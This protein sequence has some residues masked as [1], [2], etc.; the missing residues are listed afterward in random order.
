MLNAATRWGYAGMCSALTVFA[1]MLGA[2]GHACTPAF[3]VGQ[4]IY[5]IRLYVLFDAPYILLGIAVLTVL[6]FA[7]MTIPR[8]RSLPSQTLNWLAAIVPAC[9]LVIALLVPL[10]GRCVYL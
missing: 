2:F 3:S 7:I 6:V 9:V 4:A 8:I 10:H 1:A 5:W